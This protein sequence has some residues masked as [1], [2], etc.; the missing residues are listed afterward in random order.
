VEDL[1]KINDG[2][3]ALLSESL[4]T[5]LLTTAEEAKEALNLQQINWVAQLC[6][7]CQCRVYHVSTKLLNN[8]VAAR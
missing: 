6:Q 8:L 3:S 5:P 1:E 2:S 4:M 7:G